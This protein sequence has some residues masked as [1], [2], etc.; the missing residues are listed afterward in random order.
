MV[1]HQLFNLSRLLSHRK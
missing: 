1:L